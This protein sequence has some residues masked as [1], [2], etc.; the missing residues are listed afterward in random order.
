MQVVVD[1]SLGARV[2]EAEDL[3]DGGEDDDGDL[4]PAQNAELARLLEQP[5]SSLRESDLQGS[6][7]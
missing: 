3:V 4:G 2:S 6:E 5:R 1:D 7:V